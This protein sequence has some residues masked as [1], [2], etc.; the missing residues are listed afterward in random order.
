MVEHTKLEFPE[1]E[2]YAVQSVEYIINELI[3]QTNS[4][5]GYRADSEQKSLEKSVS[6]EEIFKEPVFRI[7]RGDILEIVLTEYMRQNKGWIKLAEVSGLMPPYRVGR[8]TVQPYFGDDYTE[9]KFRVLRGAVPVCFAEAIPA[10]KNRPTAE[11]NNTKIKVTIKRYTKKEGKENFLREYEKQLT[12]MLDDYNEAKKAE[13]TDVS[14][15]E[16]RRTL[17]KM[18]SR[19]N[20]KD[21]ETAFIGNVGRLLAEESSELERRAGKKTDRSSTRSTSFE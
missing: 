15:E 7:E 21:S 4:R 5:I 9:M 17:A 14:D 11:L 12:C 10:L 6:R 16:K 18:R 8:G 19:S 2:A 1:V 13:Q 20:E 3:K